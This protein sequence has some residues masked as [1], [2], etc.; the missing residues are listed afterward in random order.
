M[1]D[2]LTAVV[3]LAGAAQEFSRSLTQ[4]HRAFALYALRSRRA[5]QMLYL[6]RK[7]YGFDRPWYWRWY[8][9]KLWCL[10][11]EARREAQNTDTSHDE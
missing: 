9:Y 7:A 11:L 1:T 6:S 5:I 2:D 4:A 3:K 10:R 8:A